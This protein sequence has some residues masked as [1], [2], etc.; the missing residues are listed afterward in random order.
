[1]KEYVQVG[2]VV[3]LDD[4]LS[5]D[6]DYKYNFSE[7]LKRLYDIEVI[8]EQKLEDREWETGGDFGLYRI[9]GFKD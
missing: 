3:V 2:T 9:L 7:N 1:M 8:A 5:S 6:G 4:I